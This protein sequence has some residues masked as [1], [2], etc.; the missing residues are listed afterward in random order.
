[1]PAKPL[2]LGQR[3]QDAVTRH[4]SK[5][6]EANILP[7]PTMDRCSTQ[8]TAMTVMSHFGGSRLIPG[9]GAGPG[10]LPQKRAR[11]M[12]VSTGSEGATAINHGR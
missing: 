11:C 12:P 10:W 7:A 1:V 4:I 8:P 5:G 9:S 3:S 2:E 6:H